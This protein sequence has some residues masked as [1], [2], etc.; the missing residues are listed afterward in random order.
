MSTLAN[1]VIEV[2]DLSAV[3]CVSD[4]ALEELLDRYAFAARQVAA[5]T[6]LIAGEIARRSSRELGYSGLS[7]RTGDRTPEAFV[8]RVARVAG[9]EARE[10][11]EVGRQIDTASPW[12]VDVVDGVNSGD[13]T[14]G[15]AAAITNGLGVPGANV[16]ADDLFDAAKTLVTEAASLPPEKVARRAREA[17]RRTGCGRRH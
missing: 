10:L 9:P 8:A 4:L 3:A 17:A 16:S 1:H 11:V 15:A 14:V 12:F 6:A 13:L 2:P 7:Q 5:G